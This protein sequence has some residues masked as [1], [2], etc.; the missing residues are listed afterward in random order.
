MRLHPYC[1]RF[2][3][4][5]TVQGVL[6]T[7]A[8][9]DAIS[10]WNLHPELNHGLMPSFQLFLASLI[11][12]LAFLFDLG[13]WLY[14]T[15]LLTTGRTTAEHLYRRNGP[16]V[17]LQHVPRKVSA[18]DQGIFANLFQV[19]CAKGPAIYKLPPKDHLIELAQVETVCDNRYYSCCR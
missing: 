11:L 15:F 3:W 17:Y 18:F 2:W 14:H 1:C 16:V 8:L 6:I 7:W 9:M 4:F 5:L 13:L 12:F 19:C 10:A